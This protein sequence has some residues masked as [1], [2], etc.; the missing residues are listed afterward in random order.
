[1]TEIWPFRENLRWPK[2][3]DDC[4]NLVID[5][6]GASVTTT[7][8]PKCQNCPFRLIIEAYQAEV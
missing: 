5:C 1:M 6:V 7:K 4:Q 3:Q 2:I 8:L